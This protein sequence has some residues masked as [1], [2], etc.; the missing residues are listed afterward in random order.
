MPDVRRGAAP[1]L[2]VLRRAVLLDVRRRLRGVRSPAARA[3]ALR[4]PDPPQARLAQAPTPRRPPAVSRRPKV[5]TVSGV[6]RGAD[7]VRALAPA[8]VRD[9][10]DE[11]LA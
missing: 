6:L 9:L 8:G 2:P 7:G 3:R 4:R 1:S 5:A 10:A 11:R